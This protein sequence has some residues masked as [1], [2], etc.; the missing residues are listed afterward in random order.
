[1][2]CDDAERRN[3]LPLPYYCDQQNHPAV[4]HCVSII[5]MTAVSKRSFE[6]LTEYFYAELTDFFFFPSV[7][8][9]KNKNGVVIGASIGGA[10]LLTIGMGVFVHVRRRR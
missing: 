1:M 6:S 4:P 9:F 10:I 7:S 2:L 5:T 8:I 3:V